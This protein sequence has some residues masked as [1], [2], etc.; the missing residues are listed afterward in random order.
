M[1]NQYRI[2]N[3]TLSAGDLIY[4]DSFANAEL[5]DMSSGDLIDGDRG[6]ILPDADLNNNK[7]RVLSF[8]W[9]YSWKDAYDAGATTQLFYFHAFEG[10]KIN[11]SDKISGFNS[12]RY[13]GNT[14]TLF[15]KDGGWHFLNRSFTAF[16]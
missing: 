15:C 1:A 10:Q 16:N 2:S 14:V 4:L 8:F 7:N 12:G 5:F 11:Y 9:N 13:Y 6:V 3:I